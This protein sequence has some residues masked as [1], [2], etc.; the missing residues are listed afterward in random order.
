MKNYRS[1]ISL[2][3]VIF[4][5]STGLTACSEK[6]SELFEDAKATVDPSTMTFEANNPAIQTLRVMGN[7]DFTLKSDAEWCRFQFIKNE[8]E[9]NKTY[10]VSCAD[11]PQT[12][13]RS[14]NIRVK[15]GDN[16]EMAV[17]AINQEGLKQDNPNPDNKPS[18]LTQ[19]MVFEA[20]GSGW[21]LGNQ[22]DAYAN[23]VANETC[24]G[25]PK[26]DQTIFDAIKRAGF[27][28]VRIPITWMGHIGNAPDYKIESQWL[29]RVAQLVQYAENAGLVAIINIHHDGANSEHWLDV[30]NAALN[31]STNENIEQKLAAVWSQIAKRFADKG[32]FLIFES[33]NEIHDGGWGW[34]A[35][36]TDG[37]KQYQTFN[38]WQQVFVDAV[39]NA[40]G[41]N[42]TRWLGIP[43]YCTNIDL[44][45]ELV[46]PQDPSNKLMVAVHC[47]EPY[48]YT[49]NATFSEWGH[50]GAANAKPKNDEGSLRYEMD[51]VVNYWISKGIP[52]YIGEFGCVRRDTDRAEAFRKYYLKYYAKAASE[53]KL[54][55]IYWDNG[56]SGTGTEQSGLFNRKTG[57]FTNDS[58]E[59]VNAMNDCFYNKNITLDQVFNSAP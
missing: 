26:V 42:N 53:R 7:V 5:L 32:D 22:M 4:S 15:S 45:K 10:T 13:T 14:T 46:L 36:R 1:L 49:L 58:E 29:D 12:D 54:P 19:D 33:M 44:S 35:N 30:K 21:N 25:N 51:A 20:I 38:H 48:E 23:E 8:G 16:K 17:V 50:S 57:E 31:P 47:Y 24:W 37:G 6:T 56:A 2:A 27:K 11:N 55:I 34:G 39:R 41:K 3:F 40:G 18:D 28:S 43:T 9:F 52:A 59:I